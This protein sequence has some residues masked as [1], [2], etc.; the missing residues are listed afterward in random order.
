MCLTQKH[1][2]WLDYSKDPF[3]IKVGNHTST[4]EIPRIKTRN[5]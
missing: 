2:A 5:R 1:I 3:P 4:Q